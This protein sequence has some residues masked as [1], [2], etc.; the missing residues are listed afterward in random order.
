MSLLRGGIDCY[1]DP[2]NAQ[3]LSREISP[4]LR[5]LLQDPDDDGLGPVLVVLRAQAGLLGEE[6]SRLLAQLT[7]SARDL[8]AINTKVGVWQRKV[9]ALAEADQTYGP[10]MTE[11]VARLLGKHAALD[12][13]TIDSE[14]LAPSEQEAAAERQSKTLQAF[15][16][17]MQAR[18]AAAK[19]KQ[20]GRLGLYYTAEQDGAGGLVGG[21]GEAQDVPQASSKPVATAAAA[22]GGG[23]RLLLER[24]T[25][26]RHYESV[27]TLAPTSYSSSSSSSSQ[28]YLALAP[29]LKAQQQQQQLSSRASRGSLVPGERPQQGGGGKGDALAI[30]AL[31]SASLRLGA[32]EPGTEGAEDAELDLLQPSSLLDPST[33]LPR[34]L[35]FDTSEDLLRFERLFGISKGELDELNAA[36]VAPPSLAGGAS[37][38][39]FAATAVAAEE[40]I[41][42][43]RSPHAY[44]LHLHPAETDPANASSDA[45]LGARASAMLQGALQQRLGNLLKYPQLH[46]PPRPDITVQGLLAGAGRSRSRK[47]EADLDAGSFLAITPSLTPVAPPV[48]SST[49]SSFASPLVRRLA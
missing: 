30:A 44:P 1:G 13:K 38:S 17:G 42:T 5:K 45:L 34:R 15:H 28:A 40:Q 29:Q 48:A 18:T 9:A 22:A 25:F 4:E 24:P 14:L 8:D 11:I 35:R 36:L 47:D 16:K 43:T 26:A 32:G 49:K 37:T 33:Q 12:V 41:E 10:T 46:G 39:S 6:R 31:A 27:V 21:D 23:E 7:K 3:G 2:R 20:R 19:A